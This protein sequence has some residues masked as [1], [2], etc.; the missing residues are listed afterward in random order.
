MISNNESTLKL[1][2]RLKKKGRWYFVLVLTVN[3]GNRR[4]NIFILLALTYYCILF[5]SSF[6]IEIHVRNKHQFLDEAKT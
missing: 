1:V 6:V 5:F 3:L 2:R 4:L